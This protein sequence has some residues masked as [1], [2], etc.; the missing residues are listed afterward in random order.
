MTERKKKPIA[1]RILNTVC[2]FGLI[3]SAVYIFFAGITLIPSLILLAAI[4]GISGPVVAGGSE[5]IL[6]CF[7]SIL[8]SFVEG[9]VGVF[10][11]IG[12]LFSSF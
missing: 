8:E 9:I 1:I 4:G 2:A 11:A 7:V 12:N 5:G 6:E 10:E 3:G